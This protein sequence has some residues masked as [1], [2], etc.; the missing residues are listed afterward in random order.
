MKHRTRRTLSVL[1]MSVL[2]LIGT[3]VASPSA[4]AVTCYGDYCSGKDPQATGCAASGV[5]VAAIDA[6]FD[7]TFGRVAVYGGRLELRWSP[8]CKTNWA[9]FAPQAGTSYQLQAIQPETNYKQVY[10]AGAWQTA[11]TS[12]IYSPVKCVYAQVVPTSIGYSR[13]N[14]TSCI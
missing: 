9:R 4:S 8:T 2:V 7:T 1:F 11:W 14:K 10:N 13:A 12:Q 5:T 6:Y 3:I